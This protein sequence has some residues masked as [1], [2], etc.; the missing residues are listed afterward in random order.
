MDEAD[1]GR[2]MITI[3]VSGWINRD[4]LF[5]RSLPNGITSWMSRQLF[6]AEFVRMQLW[7]EICYLWL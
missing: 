4:F 3:G 1:K 5:R 2:L 6:F 7:G